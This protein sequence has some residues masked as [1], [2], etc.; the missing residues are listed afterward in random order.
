MD[1]NKFL[2]E[3]DKLFEQKR[4]SD[5]EPFLNINMDKAKEEDDKSAQFTILNEMMGFFRDTSQYE[6]SIKAC[7]QCIQLMK[8]M[9]I[10][11][12]VDYATAL[13]NVANAYRAA[14]MLNESLEYYMETFKIY[15][16]NID[17][18][19]YRF[20]S[21]NNNIALLY[22]EMGNYEKSVE[23]LKKALAII[24][25]IP[26]AQIEVATTESNLGA[27]LIE[28][29]NIPE[30][31]WYLNNALEIYQKDTVKNFHYSAALS[32]MATVRCKQEN[33]KEAI[34]LYKEALDE[35]EINMGKGTA[36]AITKDNLEKA[37]EAYNRQNIDMDQEPDDMQEEKNQIEISGIELSKK[38][39]MEYGDSMIKEKFPEYVDK[40]AVGLVG[41]GSERFGFDDKYSMDHDFGPGFCMWVTKSTYAKIGQQ[42]QEEYDKLP[43]TY[44][45][46]T[47]RDTAMAKGRVGVSLIGDFY[48]K[49]TG[50]RQSPDSIDGWLTIDDSQ[51][52]TVTNGEVFKDGEGIFTDIRKHFMKQPEKVRL[53]NLAKELSSMAQTGQANYGRS[54]GRK[55]YITA[56]LCISKF[57][58]HAMKCLYILNKKYA[59]YYKWLFKGTEKFAV[60]PELRF[61]IVDLIDAKDQ[62]ENWENYSYKNTEINPDD[63]KSVIIEKIANLVI[64]E[65]KNQGIIREIYSNFLD[66]YVA[67]VMEKANYNRDAVIDEIIKLEFEAFDKVENEGG[68]AECQND[69]PYFYVMRKSQYMT[70]TDDMLLTI[71]DLWLEN[72][73]N[74]WNMITEKY[75][76]MM[77]S[78][79]PDEYEKLKEYFPKRSEKTKAIV[80]Q[81]ADIQVQWMEDFAKE[82]PKLAS[83]ARNITSQTD[84]LYDTSYETYLKGELLTYSDTLLKMYAEFIIDLYNRQENLAKLTIRNTA[85][86]QGYESLEKAE[87][88]LQ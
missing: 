79:A 16:A 18:G 59:P 74:G 86:L 36:Y 61:L 66:E 84:S 72:K 9:G 20:A 56:N 19:D 31:E 29:G 53:V 77:E 22:Q 11:H 54:M 88:S 7:Q 78:T 40:I 17:S 75:G 28:T 34:E 58:E 81:I 80:D 4:I 38:F 43:K 47:R 82:Y 52:A 21:L 2:D 27:S 46:V 15:E 8:S 60:L 87:E 71:R 10:E 51:L 13:Q 69:W 67:P 25:N 83:Q 37:V 3:L 73:A 6:K 24:K 42:L 62:R 23:H 39:Y 1:V 64:Y 45:G 48:E 57:A 33:Y 50:F 26:D 30:A 14:G 49:Y 68:R 55:D 32:A 12:T 35:I 63:E 70:W 5:V 65:L 76:R 44:M 41:E 85:N